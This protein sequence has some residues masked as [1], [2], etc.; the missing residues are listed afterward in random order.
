MAEIRTVTTLRRKQHQIEVAIADYEK[1]LTQ[2]R[3][4]LEHVNAT[5]AI[6]EA[7]GD[8]NTMLICSGCSKAASW[9]RYAKRRSQTAQRTRARSR[10]ISWKQRAWMPATTF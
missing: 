8:T 9:P 2:A 10:P 7:S 4:D 1:R 6:F 3:S 5:I